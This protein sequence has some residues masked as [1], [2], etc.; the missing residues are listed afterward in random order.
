[1]DSLLAR[2]ISLFSQG[3]IQTCT[4]VHQDPNIGRRRFSPRSFS[5]LLSLTIGS[6][7]P[8]ISVCSEK[9]LPCQ[10]GATVRASAKVVVGRGNQE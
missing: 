6:D 5:T 10:G 2:G 9:V 4:I 8:F 1:M 3:K 7:K